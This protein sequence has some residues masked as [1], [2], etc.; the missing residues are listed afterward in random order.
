MN[1]DRPV[2]AAAW[3]F[4]AILLV[5]LAAR[6]TQILPA[7]LEQIVSESD[8]IF[9]G[10][11]TAVRDG[12]IPE[13]SIPFTEYTFSVDKPIKG[14]FG[15]T[16]IV[17]H[18]GVRRPRVIGDRTL[19]FRVPGMPV[20]REGQELMLFLH[21]DSSLGLSSPVGLSQGAFQIV[22]IDG[23][24]MVQNGFRNQGLFRGIDARS[25]AAKWKLSPDEKRIVGGEGPMDYGMFVEIVKKLLVEP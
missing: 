20:Y 25:F 10:T 24:R 12:T 2:G 16:V 17:R 22:E 1:P 9:V 14:N 8:R 6:A 18:L 19:V 11:C 23:E 15:K 5:P 7:N 21:P 3:I 4:L 13:T